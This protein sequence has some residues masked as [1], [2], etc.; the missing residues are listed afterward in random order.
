MFHLQQPE[1]PSSPRHSSLASNNRSKEDT[2]GERHWHQTVN[3]EAPVEFACVASPTPRL[4]YSL[5]QVLLIAEIWSYLS[6]HI[7][8]FSP[9]RSVRGSQLIRSECR[10]LQSSGI[11]PPLFLNLPSPPRHFHSLCKVIED[12]TGSSP[13]SFPNVSLPIRPSETSLP[14]RITRIHE[15]KRAVPSVLNPT[16]LCSRSI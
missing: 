4:I 8:P 14:F 3:H 6:A 2:K 5:S 1:A 15:K 16:V 7:P 9:C 12:K 13:L 10:M 11:F